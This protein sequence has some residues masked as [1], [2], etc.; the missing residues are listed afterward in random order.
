LKF[1]FR[2]TPPNRHTKTDET[3]FRDEF[4]ANFDAR[5]GAIENLLPENARLTGN[6]HNVIEATYDIPVAEYDDYFEAYISALNTAFE[7]HVI[8]N[9][10]L[11]T[12]LD[13]V[14]SETLEAFQ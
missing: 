1:Y 13:D 8:E 6:M 10:E 2:N 4:V 14:Y 5:R 3:N 9:S 12:A 11:V 7:K